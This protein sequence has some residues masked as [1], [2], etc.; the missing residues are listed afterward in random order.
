MIDKLGP[1]NKSAIDKIS[2]KANTF[3]EQLNKIQKDYI[4]KKKK[5]EESQSNKDEEMWEPAEE[6]DAESSF[7]S[8]LYGPNSNLDPDQ[9]ITEVL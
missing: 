5:Q 8:I 2:K 1:S 7:Y 9:F 4:E 3:C 6:N